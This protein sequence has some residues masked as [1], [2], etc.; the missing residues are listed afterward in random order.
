MGA[1]LTQL[2]QDLAGFGVVIGIVLLGLQRAQD[3][4]SSRAKSGSIR[5]F[6]SETMAPNDAWKAVQ[7]S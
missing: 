6:C 4:Q 3:A 1:R 2:V 5:M 7:D